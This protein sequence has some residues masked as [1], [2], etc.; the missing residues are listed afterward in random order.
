MTLLFTIALKSDLEAL[1][2]S[3][4]AWSFGP[5]NPWTG[6]TVLVVVGGLGLAFV[7]ARGVPIPWP[8]LRLS[9]LEKIMLAALFATYLAVVRRNVDRFAPRLE[10]P[11]AMPGTTSPRNIALRHPPVS[12]CTCC[13]CASCG[14]GVTASLLATSHS[15]GGREPYCHSVLCDS[16]HEYLKIFGLHMR[17]LLGT[18]A[19]AQT[20]LPGWST[21]SNWHPRSISFFCDDQGPSSDPG[22]SRAP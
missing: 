22:V 4:L 15:S 2:M 9:N 14:S 10:M 7:H 6:G 12:S 1:A 18:I 21:R 13:H 17:L 8:E 11:H 16:I 20:T 5:F 19:N 3:G